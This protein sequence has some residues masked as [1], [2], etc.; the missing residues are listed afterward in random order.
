MGNK[1]SN[2]MNKYDSRYGELD[3]GKSEKFVK[4][5]IISSI[6]VSLILGGIIS[7]IIAA[8]HS[9]LV[10]KVIDVVKPTETPT[11]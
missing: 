4:S 7:I 5:F 10:N 1:V 6:A 8:V 9:G 2:L 3:A 11:P